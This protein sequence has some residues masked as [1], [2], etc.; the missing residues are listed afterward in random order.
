MNVINPIVYSTA[1]IRWLIHSFLLCL[2][3]LQ[4]T[5]ANGQKLYK[6]SWK[7]SAAVIGGSSLLFGSGIIV[8]ESKEPFTVDD[9]ALLDKNSVFRFDR[10][11]IN[12]FSLSAKRNS[13]HFKNGIWAVPFTLLLS[14]QGRDNTKEILMMYAEVV[15]LNA[16][17]TQITK[18]SLGR[19]RPFTYNANVN[20]DIKL[21]ADARRSFFSG[22]V[23]HV[24]GL[25][26]FTA[27]VFSDLYPD[28]NFKYLVWAGAIT[29]PAITGYLRAKAGSHFPTDLI[30]GYGVGALVG[31]FIPKFHTITQKKNINISSND[32]KLG[33]V[34]N[35]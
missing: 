27:A 8:E 25:S 17:L 7:Q 15:S 34:Y 9:I 28:S 3:L 22:H 24:A 30:M 20:L 4:V 21:E 26:Y 16:G 13:D 33:L 23:S 12:N 11:A 18:R 31:Y 6:A 1:N 2:L 19:N 10:N 32:G 35:F 29:T 5:K 14:K